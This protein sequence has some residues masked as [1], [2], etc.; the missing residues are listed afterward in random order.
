[1]TVALQALFWTTAALIA[2]AYFGYPVLLWV[3]SRF[4]GKRPV[5]VTD[6]YEPTVS[7][8]VAAHNE[9]KVIAEKLEN[10]LTSEYPK[11]KLEIIVA[12]NGCTDGTD[13]IVRSFR[14]RGVILRSI[15]E[16]GKTN[17]QDFTAPLA[18]G[19]I[20]IFS[21]ADAIYEPDTVRRLVSPFADERV[22]LVQGDSIVMQGEEVP[23]DKGTQIYLRYE[24]LVKK[25]ESCL[26]ACVTGYGGILAMRKKLF[27]PIPS[28][29][30]EDFALPVLVI[31]KGYRATFQSKAV[32]CEKARQTMADEFMVR[33]RIVAQDAMAFFALLPR[34]MRPLQALPIFL[35]ASHKLL[36]W[37]V[38]FLLIGLM[39]S[40]LALSSLT[41]YRWILV[42][43]I[44]FY[45]L[46]AVGCLFQMKGRRSRLAY[47]PYYFCIVNVAAMVGF[48]E[49]LS[50]VKRPTWQ[51]AESS[52]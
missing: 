40:A 4:R 19:E 31:A 22:G 36:R 38:P 43:Q 25:L 12:S 33:V 48:L 35:L 39:S 17:A 20:I 5:P 3:L 15:P 51:R 47:I 30:M 13:E 11:D 8:I 28:H 1:M 45:L 16:P 50:G 2:Y 44:I 41:F 26:G 18:S 9:E 24:R 34:L 14:D 7:L 6:D 46:A 37:L 52:R 27:E 23:V 10:S 32:M 29:L 49:M 42:A 21:D